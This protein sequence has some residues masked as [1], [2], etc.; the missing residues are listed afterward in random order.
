MKSPWNP[1]TTLPDSNRIVVGVYAYSERC[2]VVWDEVKFFRYEADDD[3]WCDLEDPDCACQPPDFW[4]D[5]P[6]VPK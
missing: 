5:L 3:C 1:G 6:E 2:V 4:I